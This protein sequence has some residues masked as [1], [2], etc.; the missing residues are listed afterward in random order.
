MEIIDELKY[1]G[2]TGQEAAIYVCLLPR[3]QMTG[4]EVAKETGISRSNTYT[5]LAGLV[6]KGAAY[7]MEGKVTTYTA[8]PIGEFCRNRLHKLEA[9]RDDLVKHLPARK[10]PVEGY[11][12]ITGE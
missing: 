1:F 9:L 8:V 12:T 7:V 6:D 3:E 2:L 5:A 10:L 11:I 4:Y